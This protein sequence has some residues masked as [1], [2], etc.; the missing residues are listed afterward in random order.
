MRWWLVD[1]ANLVFLILVLIVLVL[2]V[3][4]RL[5]HQ[6]KY[7]IGAGAVVALIGVVGGGSAKLELGRVVTQ[8]IRLA[9]ATCGSREMLEDMVRA[10]DTHRLKRAIADVQSDLRDLCAGLAHAV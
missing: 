9:A 3:R 6:G 5:T 7:L 8:A 1:N 4:W 2:A 10:I